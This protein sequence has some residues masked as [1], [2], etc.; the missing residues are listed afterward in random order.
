[1]K[2]REGAKIERT[3]P[4]VDPDKAAPAAPAAKK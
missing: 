1:M 3:E 4:P 2:L